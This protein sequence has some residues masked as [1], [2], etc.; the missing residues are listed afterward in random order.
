VEINYSWAM[1]G[2]LSLADLQAKPATRPPNRCILSH[3]G[4]RVMNLVGTLHK[5]R[6]NKALAEWCISDAMH[7]E[8]VGE[9]TTNGVK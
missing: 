9:V 8:G 4:T 7:C 5:T 3:E 6:I 1:L 2:D